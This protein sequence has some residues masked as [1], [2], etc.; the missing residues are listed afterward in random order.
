MIVM[1]EFNEFPLTFQTH[2]TG[3]RQSGPSRLD[4]E[5]DQEVRTYDR[6]FVTERG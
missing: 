2:Q 4:G 6:R 3:L 5:P 1:V